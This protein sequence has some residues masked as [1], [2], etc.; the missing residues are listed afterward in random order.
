MHWI[1]GASKARHDAVQFCLHAAVKEAGGLTH[2]GGFGPRERGS[3]R[4]GF[5]RGANTHDFVVQ[6]PDAPGQ[7]LACD[8][9][10]LYSGS[11]SHP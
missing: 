6:D 2:P 10:V 5:T 1:E 9:K 11:D 7:L 4:P 8:V 3:P